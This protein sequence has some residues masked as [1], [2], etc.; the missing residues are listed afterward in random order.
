M[1][2][3]DLFAAADRV[4]LGLDTLN[5]P[6]TPQVD[7]GSPVPFDSLAGGP[8]PAGPGSPFQTPSLLDTKTP[9]NFLNQNGTSFI[10]ALMKPNSMFGIQPNAPIK[11]G[12]AFW[13]S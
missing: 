8:T 6:S 5:T 13:N 7:V 11:N 4:R 10:G 1:A 12:D 9:F 2:L 3:P